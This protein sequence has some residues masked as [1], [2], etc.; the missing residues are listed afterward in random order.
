VVVSG[1][2]KFHKNKSKENEGEKQQ[3]A[4]GAG[5]KAQIVL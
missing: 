4:G 3:Q 1:D 2:L 5:K